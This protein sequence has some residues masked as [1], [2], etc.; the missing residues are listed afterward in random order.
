MNITTL[1]KLLLTLWLGNINAIVALQKDVKTLF[2]YLPTKFGSTEPKNDIQNR[3]TKR[4]LNV[5]DLDILEN[6]YKK[7]L[8][9]RLSQIKELKVV[10]LNLKAK[11]SWFLDESHYSNEGHKN[12]TCFNK[13]Y[14]KEFVI[15]H[16]GF[17]SFYI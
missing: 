13:S 10:D 2:I 12:N 11:E 15:V 3:F 5:R 1:K 7:T 14:C 6:D 8:L 4:N 16:L 9:A 17:L